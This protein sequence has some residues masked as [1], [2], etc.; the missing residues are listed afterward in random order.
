M[1]MVIDRQLM[2]GFDLWKIR[3]DLDII[4][5]GNHRQDRNSVINVGSSC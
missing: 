2:R 3:K 1:A 4:E 5:D